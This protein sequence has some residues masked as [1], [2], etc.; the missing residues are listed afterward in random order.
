[1]KKHSARLLLAGGLVAG[2]L[3]TACSSK[4]S[5]TAATV[6]SGATSSGATSETT[7]PALATQG[8][9]GA[10][11]TQVVAT[12]GTHEDAA[13]YTWNEANVVAITLNGT[14]ASS[15]SQAVKV[16]GATV[17]I[18]ASGTYRL[19]GKLSDGQVIVDSAD[20]GT[21]RLILNGVEITNSKGAAISISDAKK[22]V[23]ILA[24]GTTNKLTDAANYQFATADTDEPNAAVF[25]SADLTIAGNGSLT[26]DANYNDGITSKDGLIIAGG[27]ITVVAKDDGIRGKDYVVIK[28]GSLDVTAGGDGLKADNSEDASL[29]FV[30]ISG[31]TLKVVAA[32]D[33]IDAESQVSISDGKFSVT[34]GGG[35][36]KTVAADASAKGVKG[37]AAVTISAGTFVLDTADDGIHSN[38]AISVSGGTFTIAT[39]DDALHADKT[40]TVAGGSIDITKSYEG[41]ESAAI[42]IS[43]GSIKLVSSDDGLNAAGGVDGSGVQQP[44]GGRPRDGFGAATGGGAYTITISGGTTWLNAQGDG[45]DA[46]GSV[47]MTAGTVL[48]QGPTVNGNGAIDYDGTFMMS[49]GTIVAVGSSGMAQ[50]PSATS[51][52]ASLLIR[53]SAA[54]KA[55]TLVSIRTASGEEVIT[56]E[57]AKS[58]QS[59][60]VSSPKLTAGTTYDVYLGGSSTGTNS[61]GLIEGGQYSGGTKY[62]TATTTSR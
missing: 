54:Q 4:S 49:G 35:S 47:T 45:V 53:F 32:G 40:L 13:D 23:V 19:S 58:F 46:N 51:T 9:S 39:G 2:L 8:T 61:G 31:G 29:G 6:T 55:G 60:A 33:G 57:A 34:T 14:S 26:V 1:M 27:T 11:A 36:G 28:A 44:G 15:N 48:V 24:D 22:A 10:T 21:V 18:S 30:T 12:A 20:D 38:D 16:S 41:I 37:T 56:F 52:Q 43:G 3:A 42:T 62:G 7:A 25:S 5:D 59:I 17:T 50:A